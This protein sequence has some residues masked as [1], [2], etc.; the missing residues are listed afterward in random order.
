PTAAPLPTLAPLTGNVLRIAVGVDPASVEPT[1]VTGQIANML[2]FVIEPLVT[3]DEKGAIKPGLAE[4]WTT[5]KDGDLQ[6]VQFKLRKGVKFHDGTPLNAEA[7]KVMFDRW[8]NPEVYRPT[9]FLTTM[10]KKF[11]VVDENTIKA[12][13]EYAPE[14]FL[15]FILFTGFS[16]IS[17]KSLTVAP[18]EMKKIAVPVGTGAYKWKEYARAQRL[19][20]EKNADYWGEKPHYDLVEFRIIPDATARE[21]A[22]L[23]GQV[24]MMISPPAPDIPKLQQDK[25]LKVAYAPGMRIIYAPF[26]M[27]DKTLQNVKVRQA[28]N[29]AIDRKAILDKVLFGVSEV[30]QSPMP[31]AYNGFCEQKPYNYDPAKAKALLAEA[32]GKDL[33]LKFVAPTGRYFQDFPT[34]QAIGG[35]LQDIGVEATPSTMP[36]PQYV[37]EITKKAEDSTLQMHY[38]GFAAPAPDAALGMFYIYAGSQIAPAGINTAYYKNDEVDKLIEAAFRESDPAKRKDLAC[39]AQ[40]AIWNDPPAIFLFV[41][42]LVIAHSAKIGNIGFLPGERFAA[43][44]AKP[45]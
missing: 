33:K 28:L 22:L 23:A 43:I 12:Y 18:N 41:E 36:F 16:P 27:N 4:S 8:L 2:D 17:P 29:H 45:N 20:L 34:A 14:M 15:S 25:N 3:S 44:Y 39:K 24:D 26:N 7:V 32:G 11:E 6:W 10:L 35:F 40:T 19:V 21:T 42:K 37:G 30:M 13:S 5:G 1:G 38:F 9:K 31:Q